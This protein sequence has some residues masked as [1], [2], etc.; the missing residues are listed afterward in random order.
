MF[1]VYKTNNRCNSNYKLFSLS[2]N[3]G[4]PDQ[5]AKIKRS[6]QGMH[7]SHTQPERI[8][9]DACN[10]VCHNLSHQR[11]TEL[12]C[13]ICN[14]Y[15]AGNDSC[16]NM[17]I[18]SIQPKFNTYMRR[19]TRSEI[20][21]L[22]LTTNGADPEQRANISP[23]FQV[24]SLCLFNMFGVYIPTLKKTFFCLF[25]HLHVYMHMYGNFSYTCI[26]TR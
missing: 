23:Q 15:N 2:T 16:H 20:H 4:D 6:F 12:I 5:R 19:M 26:Y 8:H 22:M 24:C 25:T 9:T 21:V 14:I 3:S 1:I 18:Y 11:Q 10:E 13:N 17:S 7:C